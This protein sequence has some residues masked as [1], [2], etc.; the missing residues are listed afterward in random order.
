MTFNKDSK[1]FV[2][3]HKGLVGSAIYNNLV[4]KG[5]KNIIVR[6]RDELDLLDVNMVRDL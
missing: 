1:I 4:N 3:G 6:S 5:Y 2:A